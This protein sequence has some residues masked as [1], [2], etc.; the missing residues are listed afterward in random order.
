MFAEPKAKPEAMFSERRTRVRAARIRCQT[1]LA[2]L[3][4]ETEIRPDPG[5]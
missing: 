2:S 5:P 3:F 1:L 4:L